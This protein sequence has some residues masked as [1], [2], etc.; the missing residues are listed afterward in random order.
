MV[1]FVVFVTKIVIFLF[2][3][4]FFVTFVP[5]SW[6]LSLIWHRRRVLHRFVAKVAYAEP[7]SGEYRYQGGRW[8][9]KRESLHYV[10]RRLLNASSLCSKLRTLGIHVADDAMVDDLGMCLYVSLW[11][12]QDAAMCLCYSIRGTIFISA[13]ASC[14]PKRYKISC[15]RF[16]C[17][18]T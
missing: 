17:I 7:K 14:S 15:W 11:I 6:S 18:Y 13:W 2:V 9:G 3:F 8:V 4:L 10:E 16:E 1:V 5:D 12:W